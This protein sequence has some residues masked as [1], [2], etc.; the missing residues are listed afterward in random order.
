G[1][2]ASTVA[3]AVAVFASR[4]VTTELVSADLDSAAALLGIGGST[5]PGAPI[6]VADGLTLTPTTTGTRHVVVIDGG[7]L[8][9]LADPLAGL[10]L[11]VLRGPCYLGLR[12][13][14]RSELQPDG[15]VLLAEAGR[16]LTRRDVG[17]VCGVPVVA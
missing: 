16:S 5:T 1:S 7:R 17:D 2:G 9:H 10:V 11:L 3:S 8:D 14:V 15:V 4:T 6:D 13:L 12:S